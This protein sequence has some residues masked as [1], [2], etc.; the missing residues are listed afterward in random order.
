MN[1]SSNI[2]HAMTHIDDQAEPKDGVSRR[3]FMALFGSTVASLGLQGCGGAGEEGEE[4]LQSA[5]QLPLMTVS[6]DTPAASSAI[7]SFQLIS[8]NGGTSLPFTL[9]HAF[10]KGQVPAG[11]TL[12]GSISELQVIPKN[13]WPDGS[14]KFAIVSGRATIAAGAPLT[15]SLSMGAQSPSTALTLDNLRATG[16]TAAIGAGT[17]GTASWGAADWAKPFSTWISGP[18]MSSWIYRKPIGND[19]HLVAWLEVRLYRGGAVEVLPWVE[20]GYLNVAGPTN[21]NAVYTFTLGGKQRFSSSID[22][23]HHCRTVLLQGTALSHWLGTAPQVIPNHDKAY[24]QSTSVVPTYFATVPSSSPLWASQTSTFQPLQKGNYANEMGSGGYSPSLGLIP[25]WDALYL[26]SNDTRAYAN[27]LM[28]AY[29]AGRFGIHYRDETT[30]RPIRFSSYPNLVVK[31]GS[32]SGIVGIGA[33]SKVQNTPLATGTKPATWAI[34]H[35]PSIAYVSYLLTGRYYFMEELQFVATINYLIQTDSTRKFS[36]G[37]FQT[38]SGSNTTRGAGWA[39]RTL[40]QATSATPDDDVLRSEFLGSLT[41]NIEFYHSTYVAQP[42]NPM[43]FV[44]PYVDYKSADGKLT[45]AAWQQDFFTASTGFALDL[46]T[47]LNAT[48]LGK[49]RAFFNWKAQSVIGRLGGTSQTEFLF[50]D[51]AQYTVAVAPVDKPDF[52]KGTGPWYA[53]WGEIYQA[54]LGVPNPGIAGVLR[55]GN[56]PNATSYW[57]NLLPAIAYAVRHKAPGAQA[58]YDRLTKASNYARLTATANDAPVWAMAPNPTQVAS[59]PA[60][61]PEAPPPVVAAPVTGLPEWVP[62][63]GYFADVPMKNNPADVIPDIYRNYPGDTASMNQ[64]FTMWGG[65]AILRD[66]SPLGAQVYYSGGHEASYTLPNIQ[67]SLICDFSTLTWS[68]ANVPNQTNNGNS[69][70]NGFAPDG[71]PYTTHTYLGLQEFP[72]AW[73]G[74]MKGSLLSF[75]F[76]GYKYENKINVLDVSKK[77]YGYS[78]M[79]TR[80][81]QNAFPSQIRFVDVGS[82][83]NHPITV[84]DNTRRGWWVTVRGQTKYTLFVSHTGEITQYPALGGN[85]ANAAIVLCDSKNLLIVAN[86][87][88]SSGTYAGTSFRT[89]HIRNLTTGAVSKS[90]T[91]GTVPALGN[92]YDGSKNTFHR[93]DTL[94][95]QWVDEL[96]CIVGLD[97][98]VSP[99]QIVK[100]S[101][102]AGN[103]ETDPWTWSRVPVAKWDKDVNGQAQLQSCSNNI[104]SKFRWVPSLHAFVYG[105]HKD[106]KPQ[107]IRIA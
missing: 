95:L 24:F 40:A 32:S 66:Y 25:E 72:K 65:S 31:G 34:P 2:D 37:V 39:L 20:N 47:G 75:F 22:L 83:D 76:A 62:P 52:M 13:A 89:L 107:I 101:P 54:T 69:I 104:Y 81:P 58:A 45:E 27:V 73:G 44:A 59:T 48:A 82:A 8:S 30:Q 15:V 67:L 97:Q 84:M 92:G 28:N 18:F 11:S 33:S 55:G 43:G 42:N 23:P 79:A 80:Q 51:A 5:A 26:T 71:T 85:L 36:G 1:R 16:V 50:S 88:Y 21:K 57:G 78:V 6:A 74:G 46:D 93:I 100:L 38:T 94:G 96:N 4:T 106:R 29:G 56:F 70:V 98:S 9:G 103:L 35:H 77:S 53:N 41:A 87:G 64:P 99:P 68:V 3:R 86:G 17:Y 105:T 7:A 49:L 60:P 90:L 91:I 102:P 14:L 63:V 61:T 19:P 10:R 12:T